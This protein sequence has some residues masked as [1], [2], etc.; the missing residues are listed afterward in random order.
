MFQRVFRE[1]ASPTRDLTRAELR[2][3]IDAV[4]ESYEFFLGYA[5]QGL[6]GHG[7]NPSIE[8]VRAFLK[9]MDEAL[10]GLADDLTTLVEREE[11]TPPAAYHALIAVLGRDASAAQAA[12]RVVLALPAISSQLIDNLNASI[13]VRA[14]LTDLF[15]LDE[16]LKG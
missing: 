3:R 15:L 6:S 16:I 8:Q 14:M 1:A 5:A 12:V 13:H 10:T 11:R 4:E 7:D 9:R 2:K